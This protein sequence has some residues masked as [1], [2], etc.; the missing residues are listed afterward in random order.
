MGRWDGGWVGGD[1]EWG[2]SA[3]T[4]SYKNG[5][6]GGNWQEHA[7]ECKCIAFTAQ[8]KKNEKVQDLD[9]DRTHY[10][11]YWRVL[12]LSPAPESRQKG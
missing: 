5:L 12:I 11:Y 6:T 9:L 1:C 8:Q 3:A 7:E 4:V 10:F 2:I